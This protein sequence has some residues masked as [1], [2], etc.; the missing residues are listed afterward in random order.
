MAKAKCQNQ[1]PN[2]SH[3][4]FEAA[5]WA[6]ADKLRDNLMKRTATDE[7]KATD[8]PRPPPASHSSQA[9]SFIPPHGG[10]DSEQDMK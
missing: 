1:K 4:G 7:T 10:Y 5:L 3:L 2:G 8:A 6:T 9:G